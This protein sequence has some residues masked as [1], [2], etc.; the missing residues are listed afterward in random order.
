MFIARTP[1]R[2]TTFQRACHHP[3]AWVQP[4][5]S[6]PSVPRRETVRVQKVGTEEPAGH[7]KPLPDALDFM[8]I[9]LKSF[10]KQECP[11]VTTSSTIQKMVLDLNNFLHLIDCHYKMMF[12]L[13]NVLLE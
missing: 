3:L 10:Y 5:L 11:Q 9:Y 6:P 12:L 1:N 2:P 8:G 13:R 7:S 4:I